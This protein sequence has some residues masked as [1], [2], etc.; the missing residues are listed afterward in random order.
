M[1]SNTT[2]AANQRRQHSLEAAVVESTTSKADKAAIKYQSM[3]LSSP[4]R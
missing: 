3:L 4:A 1:R 2:A